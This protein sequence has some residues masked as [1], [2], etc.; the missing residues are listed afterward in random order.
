MNYQATAL[1]YAYA[2]QSLAALTAKS[3]YL[4][5]ETRQ[6]VELATQAV[7]IF[8]KLLALATLRRDSGKDTDLNVADMKAQ[9]AVARSQLARARQNFGEA[10]RSLEILLGRYPAAEI[11]V[12]ASYPQLP[13]PASAGVPASVLERRPDV[14]AAERIVL[15]AFRESEAARLELLPEFSA[16]LSIGR[17]D[18]NVLSL[19]RINPWI[20]TA[21]IGTLIP[22]YEGGALRANVR[23]ANAQQAEAV[24]NYGAVVLTAFAEVE[25]ALANDQSLATRL[26]Q[27]QIALQERTEAVRIATVQY[28]AGRRDLLWVSVLQTEQLQAQAAVI[29]LRSLQGAN[30]IRLYL[31][32]GGSFDPTP[33]TTTESEEM[34]GFTRFTA[35]KFLSILALL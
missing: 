18:N 19:L 29:Q 22:I 8:E 13:P 4:T 28:L 1:D 24:A 11:K 30:R 21:D 15:A 25:N 3:W 16:T 12:A 26:V 6:M 35:A 9:L 31:A 7:Q 2:R 23:I 27:D 20:A 10:R 32:L 17:L 33:A 14:I 5:I 34:P